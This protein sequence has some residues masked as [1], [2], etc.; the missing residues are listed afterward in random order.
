MRRKLAQGSIAAGAGTLAYT[1]PKTAKTVYQT[2]IT[3]IDIANTTAASKTVLV[4]L[5]PVG[6]TPDAT[7]QLIPT[8]TIPANLSLQWT[9]EQTLNTGDYIQVI[10][11]ATGLCMNI[12]GDVEEV[13]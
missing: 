3:C 9:G 6:G 2:T 1:V 8:I 13:K 12:S 10:G 7:N 4:H 5:V 11:S